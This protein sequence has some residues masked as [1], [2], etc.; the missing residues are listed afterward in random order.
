MEKI[1][2]TDRVR[3]AVL[4]GLKF[5]R[6]VLKTI[7]EGR[8]ANCMGHISRRNCLIKHVIEGKM[9]RMIEVT[10]RR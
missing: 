7:K 1:V 10:G 2:W 5:E 8:N 6:N 9:E 4:K 3:N